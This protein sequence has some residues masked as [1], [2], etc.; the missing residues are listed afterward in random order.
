MK[1]L[2]KIFIFKN[3]PENWLG[4]LEKKIVLEI[5]A[6]LVNAPTIITS[7]E[8]VQDLEALSATSWPFHI[9][10]ACSSSN[11]LLSAAW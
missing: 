8:D 7:S 4:Q 9:H 2:W 5:Q 11:S 3:I 10:L 1:F 6:E